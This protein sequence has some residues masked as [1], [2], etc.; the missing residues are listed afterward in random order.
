MASKKTVIIKELLDYGYLEG[1]CNGC[2]YSNKCK[3]IKEK[4]KIG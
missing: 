2:L 1:E 4:E 3:Y